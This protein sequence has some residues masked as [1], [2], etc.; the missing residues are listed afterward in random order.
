MIDR[1]VVGRGNTRVAVEMP[2]DRNERRLLGNKLKSARLFPTN[3]A[4][5][6]AKARGERALKG[7]LSLRFGS[8]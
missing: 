7:T 6:K 8:N 4:F 1:I 2:R 3:A 5:Q